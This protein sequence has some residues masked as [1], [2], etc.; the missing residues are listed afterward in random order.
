MRYDQKRSTKAII[1]LIISITKFSIVIDSPHIY[2]SHKWRAITWVSNYRCPIGTFSNR[3][4]FI[5][6][7][8]DFHVNYARSSDFEITCAITPWIVR[9]EVQLLLL[10]I[11]KCYKQWYNYMY[12]L[13]SHAS[14]RSGILNPWIWLANCA[15]S[16]GSD[17]PIRTPRTGRY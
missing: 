14:E 12:L 16:S 4:P 3:T 8:H 15:C 6:Y 1:P 10:I 5:G 2:L 11:F 17:F 9:H 13:F 7:P